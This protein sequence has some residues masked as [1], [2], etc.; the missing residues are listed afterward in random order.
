MLMSAL[1]FFLLAVVLGLYLLS[2]VLRSK[3]IPKA[4]AM[5][6][7]FFAVAGLILLMVYPFYHT[8]APILSLILFVLAA[9]GGFTMAYKSISGKPVPAW[10]AMGHGTLAIIAVATLIVFIL[11]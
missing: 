6:H 8:P 9:L 1:G 2:L 11:V 4:A 7:G 10:M 3:Q 5:I